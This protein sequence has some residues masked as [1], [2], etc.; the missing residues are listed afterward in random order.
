[1]IFDTESAALSP[2]ERRV[3]RQLAAKAARARPNSQKTTTELYDPRCLPEIH[4]AV[5]RGDL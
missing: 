5:D 4:F 1:M 3:A 2:D